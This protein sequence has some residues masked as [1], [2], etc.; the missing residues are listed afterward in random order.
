VRVSCCLTFELSGRGE[1]G[2]LGPVTDNVTGGG[3]RAKTDRLGASALE[4]GVRRH[5]CWRTQG[6]RLRL[7][8][9]ERR[10][11]HLTSAYKENARAIMAS[12][13]RPSHSEAEEGFRSTTALAGLIG[14]KNTG[15]RRP[16]G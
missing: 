12:P 5:C 16:T 7:N 10:G 13:P 2:R 15:T 3:R 9:N 11:T 4:R 1:A 6:V 8:G 14:S